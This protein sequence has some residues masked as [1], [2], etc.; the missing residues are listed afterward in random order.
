VSSTPTTDPTPTLHQASSHLLFL[1]HHF[2]RTEASWGPQLC[3]FPNYLLTAPHPPPCFCLCSC[4]LFGTGFSPQVDSSPPHVQ[5]PQ[6]RFPYS[7]NSEQW[8]NFLSGHYNSATPFPCGRSKALH[9]IWPQVLES[10]HAE[11]V[12][13][14][15]VSRPSNS[16]SS[17]LH[18]V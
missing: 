2:R 14:T 17:I 8:G 15:K 13:H 4:E 7:D 1:S 16:R 5:E 11:D 9:K 10:Y 18:F 6:I 12:P 3:H